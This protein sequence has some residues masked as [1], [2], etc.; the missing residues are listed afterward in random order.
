M[1]DRKLAQF[2]EGTQYRLVSVSYH[3][4]PR[5][6]VRLEEQTDSRWRPLG[7]VELHPQLGL[8]R[9][10]K[11]GSDGEVISWRGPYSIRRKY[12]HRLVAST[13]VENAV[14]LVLRHEEATTDRHPRDHHGDEPEWTL[15]EG[16]R[17]TPD[18]VRS[19]GGDQ[20]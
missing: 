3:G 12:H 14:E 7:R 11:L 15:R 10:G 20:R 4:N 13:P 8:Q 9:E 5:R 18:A 6:F 16:W 19:L 17:V 1:T 2:G